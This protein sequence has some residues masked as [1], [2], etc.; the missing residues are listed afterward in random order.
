MPIINL[1]RHQVGT[2]Y[3]NI[4]GKKGHLKVVCN[5]F[6]SLVIG[7]NESTCQIKKNI[8]NLLQ[9]LFSFLRK[10]N[11]RILHFQILWRKKNKKYLSLNN[12]ESKHSVLMKFGQFMSHYKRKNFIKKFSR[13]CSQKTSS[14]PFYVC[15][16]LSTASIG[17]WNFWSK[18]LILD[19]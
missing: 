1:H 16:E 18:L 17:K 8:F 14:R 13:S 5:I 2:E 6:A 4:L 11:F 12:L 9:N 3:L 15:K 10:L 7:L 19:M